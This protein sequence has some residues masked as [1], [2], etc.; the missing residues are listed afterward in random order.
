MAV[1]IRRRE[2]YGTP[3]RFGWDGGFG[4][5]SYTD[6]AERMNSKH[7]APTAAVPG[8]ALRRGSEDRSAPGHTQENGY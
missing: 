4:T 8:G 5:S 6:P 3:G 1:E 2:I 7:A